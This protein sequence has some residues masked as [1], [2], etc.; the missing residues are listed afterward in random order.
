MDK[1]SIR[2]LSLEGK[3]VL[4]RVD[5]NVPIKDGKILDDVR[6]H[7]AMPTIHYLLKQDAAVILVSHVGRPK[8]GVFEEAYSLAPIVPVLEGYLGHHVPLSPDCIGEVARQAVAQ[9][10][11]GRVL[12]LENVRFHKGE[13]HSDEDPSFAIELAA[14]ADFYVNDAFG[15]SHRK[16]ASVY[17]V[18]QLFPDRAA[19]GFLMEKELEFLGQHLL[20]EPKRPFTAI[21]GGAKMSSKIG[22]I[23]ALLSCVDHLVLAGGMGYTFL[24]A[25]NRQV[26]NSLVEESGIPLAKKV[27]EKAQALGVKIHLPVDAKVAKQCD[28]GEDW[29]ELSIQEGIPEE[30]AGFDIGAQT[31][32]LFSKVIQESATIFWNGPVGVYEVPPFDQGSKAI[33][34]CLASHSSA[35]TVVGGGDA[36]AVVALAG[37]ASQISHVSTG[38]GA[39]LEFLEK[40]SLPGTEILSPAQS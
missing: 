18:P 28:S 32:E 16:H 20:V 23:E 1:L 13:E 4:V 35:V 36:A 17:R 3:K 5:F 26:G 40:G 14:Y 15:T 33:A 11:P 34:Q 39:S 2:D 10:S 21:L 7:S 37:C 9:L 12:L 30:L 24:R 19:A 38:G 22:V 29:R 27:L 8:G 6:I 25:M 31:I